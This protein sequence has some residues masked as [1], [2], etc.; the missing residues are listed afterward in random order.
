[1]CYSSINDKDGAEDGIE[2]AGSDKDLLLGCMSWSVM[3]SGFVE[4]LT[5]LRA[6]NRK[7]VT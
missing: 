4:G 5:R 6:I 3:G 2:L 1:M 7:V